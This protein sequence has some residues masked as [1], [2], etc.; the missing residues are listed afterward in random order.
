MLIRADKNP[1]N[2]VVL[3]VELN[4]K[5]YFLPQVSIDDTIVHTPDKNF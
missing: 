5:E 2:D 3:F 4:A 1:I